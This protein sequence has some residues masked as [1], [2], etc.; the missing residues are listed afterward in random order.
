MYLLEA[1]SYD[2]PAVFSDGILA[3]SAGA[4]AVFFLIVYFDQIEC[5]LRH[6]ARR[7]GLGSH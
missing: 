6:M 5:G 3:L 2:I 7:L 1:R 4:A